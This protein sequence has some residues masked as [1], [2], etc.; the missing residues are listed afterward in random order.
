MHPR[1]GI[2]LREKNRVYSAKLLP[3]PPADRGRRWTIHQQANQTDLEHTG[4]SGS[5]A[6]EEH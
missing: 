4:T 3:P 1:L 5:D 2:S 6:G